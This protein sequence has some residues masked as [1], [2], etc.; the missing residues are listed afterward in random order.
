M[1][2]AAVVAVV[3]VMLITA[4]GP[5]PSGAQPGDGAADPA[6]IEET[7]ETV[8]EALGI[9]GMAAAVVENREIVWSAGFGMADLDAGIAAEP[10]TPFGLASVTK[11]IAAT[12]VMQLV[13]EG[14]IDLDVPV[15]DYGVRVAGGGQVTVRHL[16][17]HTSEGTPGT[18]HTYNGNRY[19]LLGGVIEGA[20]GDSFAVQLG[21]RILLPLD[22]DD[23]A[24]NPFNAWSGDPKSGF[25]DF[26]RTL[27]WTDA[28]AHYPDVY[29]RLAEPYQF[30]E[31]YEIV[32]GMYQLVH[33]PAAGLVSSVEDLA[34]FD[35]A[36]DG[37]ELL[38]AGARAE[39]WAP[40]IPTVAG[41]PDLS[42]GLGWYVQDY[43]GN[44]LLW[45][46]GRWPPS[47]SAL[48]LKVPDEDLT[49]IV[50]A[51]TD[52]LTVPFPG[53]GDGDIGHSAPAL[54][55]FRHFLFPRDGIELPPIDWSADRAELVAALSAIEDSR[56][57]LL[58]ERELWSFRQ[59][60][61]SSGQI[62]Q[63]EVLRAV[64]SAAFP[65]S[66]LAADPAYTRTA[67]RMPVVPPVLSAA[68]LTRLGQVVV[69]WLAVVAMALGWMV[70]ELVRDRTARP[71]DWMLWLPA[72][73]MLGPIGP[74]VYRWAGRR[75]SGEALRASVVT[76]AGYGGA[77]VLAL[78]L[79]VN[80]GEEPN[81]LV[82]LGATVLLP[83]L[84]GLLVVRAP[85]L[86]RSGV[87]SYPAGVRRGVVAEV[88]T[89]GLAFAVLFPM[90][91]YIDDRWLS[92]IPSPSNPYFGAMMSLLAAGGLVVLVPLY[93]LMR[94]MGF[95][96]WPTAA[97]DG[98][99][100][101]GLSVPRWRN[102]RWL[103]LA[104]GLALVGALVA[105]IAVFG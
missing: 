18:V 4:V 55:F 25:E 11:P 43:E 82:V 26:E 20:T 60:F 61:A 95:T 36:L 96:V 69:G 30:G 105:T 101:G 88:I 2:S 63:A 45:H 24:L 40:A 38:G 86:R 77:W 87:G 89:W 73:A 28:F 22:M 8:R 67:E 49:F 47:T 100:D 91:F 32:P 33:S 75:E 41:R 3:L 53:I 74:A 10:S 99:P 57:R 65:G 84:V 80:A 103:V 68:S 14:S 56:T 98:V 92:T 15:A 83:A 78:G 94:R 35:I 59:A 44:R 85:L 48:Y 50:A 27:G 9:P 39:M 62:E 58:L 19:G 90:T 7:L 17:T 70:V 13:E 21:E 93:L 12:L 66:R 23:T 102:A 29:R 104:S 71:W 76:V 1:R 79:L 31:G 6:A 81:P 37:G 34:A 46:A 16:L 72:T 42:Y 97:V 52:N 64:A 54:T 5:V 51:N